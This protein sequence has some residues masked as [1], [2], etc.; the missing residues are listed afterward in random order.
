MSSFSESSQ[1]KDALP[2]PQ[3]NAS[4]PTYEQLIGNGGGRKVQD[5]FVNKG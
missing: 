2:P 3:K 5:N 1:E 4:L